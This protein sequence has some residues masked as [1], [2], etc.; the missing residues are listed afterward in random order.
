V[1]KYDKQSVKEKIK[2][3]FNDEKLEFKNLFKKGEKSEFEQNEIK[4]EELR[5]ED[6]YI[7]WED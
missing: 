2:Q 3:D 5:E 7:D 4:F 6:K 1:I